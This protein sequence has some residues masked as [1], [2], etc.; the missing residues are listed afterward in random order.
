MNKWILTIITYITLGISNL[1]ARYDAAPDIDPLDG[2]V[3]GL[4]LLGYAA[5]IFYMGYLLGKSGRRIK[6]FN[7]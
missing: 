3:S 5:V 6:F 1:L 4:E 7:R 2:P